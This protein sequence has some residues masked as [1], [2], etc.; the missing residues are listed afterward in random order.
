MI[1]FAPGGLYRRVRSAGSCDLRGKDRIELGG[2]ADHNDDGVRETGFSVESRVLASGSI[3]G[4]FSKFWAGQTVSN[5]GSSITLFALPLLV[6][7]LTGSAINL[8][9][10]TAA[11]FIPHLAFGLFIGAWVDRLDRKKLMIVVDLLRAVVISTIPL[12][13]AFDALSVWWI[14]GTGFVMSTLTIFFDSSQFA[15][16]PSLVRKRELVNANG[17]IQASYS[18][19]QV[20]GPL[21]AGVLVSVL[22]LPESFWSTQR[23]S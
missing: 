17:Q 15:A 2:G 14:Y 20:A 6:Y 10:T 5:L 16:I 22:P 8:A 23:P 12:L 21:L 19:A 3:R 7:E 11:Q 18:A 1:S 9:L 4:D 13:A